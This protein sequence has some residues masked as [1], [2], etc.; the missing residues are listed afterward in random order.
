MK[1]RVIE[2]AVWVGVVVYKSREALY[3]LRL[4]QNST[5][6]SASGLSVE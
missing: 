4:E 5:T 1:G 6:Q 2:A 3:R